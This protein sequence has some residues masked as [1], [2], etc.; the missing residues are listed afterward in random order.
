MGGIGDVAVEKVMFRGDAMVT[1][2]VGGRCVCAV[3]F[4]GLVWWCS[5]VWIGRWFLTLGVAQGCRLGFAGC[6]DSMVGSVLFYAGVMSR[7]D[8]MDV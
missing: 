3:V 1:G 8:V 7:R 2:D 4:R 5:G 6:A